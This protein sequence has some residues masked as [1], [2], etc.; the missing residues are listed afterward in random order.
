MR[1]AAARIPFRENFLRLHPG[2]SQLRLLRMVA[3]ALGLAGLVFGA[4]AFG[5]F[6]AQHEDRLDFIAVAS[7]CVLV[8]V[9]ILI[10]VWGSWAPLPVLLALSAIEAIAMVVVL[11]CWPFAHIG[12]LPESEGMPWALSISAVPIVCMAIVMRGAFVWGYLVLVAALNGVVTSAASVGP[13]SWLVALQTGMYALSFSAIFVGLVLVGLQGAERL[14][15]LQAE[16]EAQTARTA[17]REA[18]E[19]ERARFDGLIHDGVIS[20]LLMAGRSQQLDDD[21]VR[22]ARDTLA[23]LERLGSGSLAAGPVNADLLISR[24]HRMAENSGVEVFVHIASDAAE[25]TLPAEAA[26]ALLAAGG[27]ALRNSI[28][29]AAGAQ[30][31]AGSQQARS[32][33]LRP[34]S[35]QLELRVSAAAVTLGVRDDGVGFDPA[36]LRP[37]RLGIARSIQARMRSV[38]GGYSALDSRPGQGTV[39]LL[40]WVRS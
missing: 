22:Q 19:S 33:E 28:E 7:F 6:L 26:E 24:V 1:G 11:V 40:G 3:A 29:H 21:L 37:E 18:R 9:P 10:G 39:V 15:L 35:R 23:Q 20:T 2:P 27:E 25:L 38:G 4:L 17:A 32:P 31:A 34:V 14:D 13:D 5:P 30:H 36:E 16:A 8:G 12:G